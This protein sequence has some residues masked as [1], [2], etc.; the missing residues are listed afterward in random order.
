MSKKA[1]SFVLAIMLTVTMI[2]VTALCV[3]AE[4]DDDAYDNTAFS[5][6][7]LSDNAFEGEPQAEPSETSATEAST[8]SAN[9]KYPNLTVN[10]I[11][12]YF[13]RAAA[14]YNSTTKEVT[15]TYWLNLSK[16]ILNTQWYITYDSSVLSVSNRKNT[17]ASV[18]PTVGANGSL[19]LS[20][21]NTINYTATNMRLFDFTSQMVP[22][23]KIVFDVDDLQND[24]AVT[25]TIDLTVDV[26][27]VSKAD[28]NTLL[29]ADSE[30]VSLVNNCEIAKNQQTS[31]IDVDYKTTLTISNYVAP[32][33]AE[34]TKKST[35]DESNTQQDSTDVSVEPSEQSAQ[36]S[37]T[38]ATSK[39]DSPN[40]VPSETAP[41]NV[42]A[43]Q[44]NAVVNTG[45]TYLALIFLCVQI[46]ATGV[47]FV[48]RKKEMY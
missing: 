35:D 32:T 9:G 11:S 27:R 41:P 28:S 45:D 43:G 25:T 26:L 30:E 24:S 19:D 10:A 6:Y 12:N 33:T 3:Y 48:M 31:L 17:P 40:S 42:G 18:C 36:P 39:I 14:E 20:E 38:D 4:S 44:T 37:E 29:S 7:Q 21:E 15:V 8:D 23:A 34:D 1:V 5:D 16:N 47:L 2:T 22:F 46:F 13:P